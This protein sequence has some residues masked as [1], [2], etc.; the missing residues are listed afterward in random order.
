MVLASFQDDTIFSSHSGQAFACFVHPHL[1]RVAC[2]MLIVVS[3]VMSL[4]YRLLTV[5]Y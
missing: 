5:V 4:Y 1:L 3:C 2:Y